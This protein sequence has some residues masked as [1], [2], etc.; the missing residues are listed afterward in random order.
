[1]STENYRA[2]QREKR[3]SGNGF[4]AAIT[5]LVFGI[6]LVILIAALVLVPRLVRAADAAQTVL[7]EIDTTLGEGKA[8]QM[9]EDLHTLVESSSA[10]V[11]T[12]TEKLEAIDIDSLNGAIGDLA[13]VVEPLANVVE[14]L[15]GV[16][17]AWPF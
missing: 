3:R 1:M 4:L 8:E 16:V 10:G 9:L 13:T 12:A 17:E 6:F 7:T 15:R 2:Y 14:Q 5:V 11:E